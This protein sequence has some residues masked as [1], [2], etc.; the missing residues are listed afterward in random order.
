MQE[1][2]CSIDD[3]IRTTSARGTCASCGVIQAKLRRRSTSTAHAPL[4][5]SARRLTAVVMDADGDGSQN[6][7]DEHVRVASV[8]NVQKKVL[9]AMSRPQTY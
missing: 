7:G 4:S 3:T 1:R 2:A 6:V 5:A 8:G 9:E